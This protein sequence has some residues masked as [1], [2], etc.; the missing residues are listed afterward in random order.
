MTKGSI[1]RGCGKRAAGGVYLT[2][3]LS[4]RGIPLRYFLID[5]PWVPMVDGE[6]W[7]PP[8]QGLAIEPRPSD[9]NIWDVWDWI[10]AGG[11]PF[12]PDFY[13]EGA[14]FEFSRR[15]P[16]DLN[17]ELLTTKSYHVY[18]HPRGLPENHLRGNLHAD[19]VDGVSLEVC[20]TDSSDAEHYTKEFCTG[21]LWQLVGTEHIPGRLHV[22]EIPRDFKPPTFRYYAATPPKG[23]VPKWVP[24]AVLKLPIHKIEVIQDPLSDKDEENYQKVL[25]S[26]TEI[27]VEIVSE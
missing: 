13:E 24:A 2:T 11:Y 6:V 12:F 9:P 26:G 17:F 14:R 20:P 1:R 10:G 25:D 7:L 15:S 8:V 27:P 19:L 18:V 21:L 3:E 23:F 22:V 5:P 16:P 4:T